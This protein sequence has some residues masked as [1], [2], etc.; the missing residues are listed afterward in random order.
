MFLPHF[1]SSIENYAQYKIFW[2]QVAFTMILLYFLHAFQPFSVSYNVISSSAACSWI[3]IFV[4]P[5][6][7]STNQIW[8]T[9]LQFM[10]SLG[11]QSGLCA[12]TYIITL[13]FER[14]LDL[15][16][17]TTFSDRNF[18]PESTKYVDPGTCLISYLHILLVYLTQDCDLMVLQSYGI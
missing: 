12:S 2:F 3:N 1:Y 13:W 6:T 16:V 14:G 5:G 11:L 15:G 18:V 10:L 7:T 17:R 4:D 9:S 8:G